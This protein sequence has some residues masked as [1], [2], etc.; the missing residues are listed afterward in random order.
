MKVTNTSLINNSQTNES[1]PLLEN[2]S[3][4]KNLE[5]NDRWL[6]VR[7]NSLRTIDNTPY[8]LSRLGS[9]CDPALVLPRLNRDGYDMDNPQ[10]AITKY[11]QAHPQS[12]W[13]TTWNE[14]SDLVFNLFVA[15]IPKALSLSAGAD[16]YRIDPKLV[17]QV[18]RESVDKFPELKIRISKEEFSLLD[19]PDQRRWH[20]MMAIVRQAQHD[21]ITNELAKS[22]PGHIDQNAPTILYTGGRATGLL[23]VL[24]CSVDEYIALYWSDWGL[25]STDSGSYKAHVY[26]YITEGHNI[27][28]S[29]NAENFDAKDYE[30]TEPGEYTFLP[31]GKRKIWSFEGPCGMVDHGRGDIISMT[32]FALISNFTSTLNL[33]QVGKL[34]ST[35]ARA[36]AH[37]YAQRM[38]D[39]LGLSDITIQDTTH[40]TQEQISTAQ[41]FFAAIINRAQSLGKL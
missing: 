30:I 13:E 25:M 3:T 8:F 19:A 36:V 10:D 29:A 35:E 17:L 14:F 32:K 9:A 27:N 24:Y 4:T 15:C 1:I 33:E 23:R 34:L 22:Y 39:V 2:S 5:N 40:V 21:Y 38:R 41:A 28:W 16:K 37:E 18:V 6:G 31:R 12:W 20:E 26:D 11:E 7:Q